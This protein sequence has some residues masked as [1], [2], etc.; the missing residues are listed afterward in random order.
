MNFVIL[1][2]NNAEKSNYSVIILIIFWLDY[3]LVI[4]GLLSDVGTIKENLA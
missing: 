4:A 3:H 2:D 1:G